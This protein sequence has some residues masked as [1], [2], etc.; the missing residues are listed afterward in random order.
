MSVF[1]STGHGSHGFYC[2]NCGDGNLVAANV[3]AS[4]QRLRAGAYAI[5][6]A[7]NG[8]FLISGGWEDVLTPVSKCGVRMAEVFRPVGS[9]K[10]GGESGP[11]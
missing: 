2:L 11:V 3:K 5:I 4:E 9:W 8:A 6:L 1:A 7:Q 10:G